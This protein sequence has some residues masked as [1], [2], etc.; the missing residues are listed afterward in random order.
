MNTL[1]LGSKGSEVKELQ[2]ALTRAGYSLTVDG[3]FGTKTA[4]AVVSFQDRYGLSTDGIVGAKT[5]KA[6]AP[7]MVSDGEF[8][9]AFH[10]VLDNIE[11]LPSYKTFMEMITK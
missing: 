2:S 9:K 8:R 7:F 1:R 10:T 6:L 5:W 3:V 4:S 11:K